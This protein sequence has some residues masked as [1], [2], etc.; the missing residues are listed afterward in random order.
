MKR[1]HIQAHELQV[2]DLIVHDRGEIDVRELDRTQTPKIVTNP[3]ARDE[4]TGYAWQHVE[5]IR[6][7]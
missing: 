6:G 3:G 2:G 5:I 1:M 4:V 7:I